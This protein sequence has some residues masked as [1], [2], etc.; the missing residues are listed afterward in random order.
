MVQFQ[1]GFPPWETPQ[2]W[3]VNNDLWLVTRLCHQ[4]FGVSSSCRAQGQPICNKGRWTSC[5][6]HGQAIAVDGCTRLP[7]NVSQHLFL[8]TPDQPP[9]PP[10]CWDSFISSFFHSYSLHLLGFI[11]SFLG[12]GLGNST[13]P[14]AFRIPISIVLP[15]RDLY[16]FIFNLLMENSNTPPIH[17]NLFSISIPQLLV[18]S[19]RH[20]LLAA[21]G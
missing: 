4:T 16:S 13:P 9:T 3:K 18:P 17:D 11:P 20:P 7:T 21:L 10:I 15:N 2:L 1:E 14:L 8:H 6:L 12:W 5:I 19:T